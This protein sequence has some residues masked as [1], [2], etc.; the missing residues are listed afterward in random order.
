MSAA[1]PVCLRVF[2]DVCTSGIKKYD[3][4]VSVS[5]KCYIQQVNVGSRRL[6]FG[7]SFKTDGECWGL[8]WCNMGLPVSVDSDSR[9]GHQVQIMDGIGNIR[10]RIHYGRDACHFSLNLYA[11]VH[12]EWKPTAG[13]RLR[14]G[15]HA[16]CGS[17]KR[18]CGF[19]V[20]G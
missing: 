3:A 18:R 20:Q 7:S 12:Q 17:S 6:Q 10:K 15:R 16:L 4:Y 13:V 9:N 2:W 19:H 8:C 11:F 5:V 14:Q 1:Q